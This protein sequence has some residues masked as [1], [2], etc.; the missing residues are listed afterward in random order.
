MSSGTIG[1]LLEGMHTVKF[2]AWD[3]REKK[4]YPNL[5]IP[6]LTGN[7]FT[8]REVIRPRLEDLVWMLYSGLP[9]THGK[10]IAAADIVKNKFE[11]LY[12]VRYGEFADT[13]YH[14][15]YGF[16]LYDFE[17]K[18]NMGNM[19]YEADERCPLEVVGNIYEHADLL[20][21]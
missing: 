19:G 17:S 16:Y 5:T 11:L 4:M 2:R 13:K 10:E 3:T 20:R 14:V 8:A 1:L 7:Y 15:Q 12:E 9:D 6:R 21:V 18:M